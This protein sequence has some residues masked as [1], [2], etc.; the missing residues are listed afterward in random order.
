MMRCWIKLLNVLESFVA[1]A[2]I[3]DNW[4][5]SELYHPEQ[6]ATGCFLA[7]IAEALAEDEC[8][9]SVLCA[10]PSYN[11]RG[12]KAPRNEV[13]HGVTIHRCWSTTWD[14]RKVIGRLLNVFTNSFSIGFRAILSIKRSDKVLVVTNPPLLPY[15]VRFACWLKGAKFVFLVHDVYPDV[16]VPLGVMKASN[17]LYRLLSS[18]NGKLYSSADRVVAL[19]RDMAKLVEEKSNGR[20]KID[21]ITNWGDVDTICPA[22]KCENDMLRDMELSGKFIVHYSGNHGR[23]HDLESIVRAA[24]LLREDEDIHFLFIGEGSGK[25]AAV[26]LADQLELKNVSFRSFVDRSALPTSL[27][28]SDISLLAFKPGMAGISV[29]S[30]MYNMMAAGKPIIGIVDDTSEVAAVIR[31]A[32]MGAVVPPESPEK[33]AECIKDLKNDAESRDRKG[34]NAR[35]TVEKNYS[36]ISISQQYR[37]LFKSL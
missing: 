23:T 21:I 9:V 26:K 17:P 3:M 25:A 31:E 27:N 18:I 10:Q 35:E 36:Y 13:R 34:R 29:P 7:G 11:Q 30:R 19:G 14:P 15:F 32:Q 37:G 22:P 20:A 5:I 28:A 8:S 12:L 6:N 24:V 33:L 4:I 2:N 1:Y 16:F